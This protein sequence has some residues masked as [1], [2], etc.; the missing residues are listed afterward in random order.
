MHDFD[1]HKK[2]VSLS[3]NI[4]TNQVSDLLTHNSFLL[5]KES[6]EKENSSEFLI[7]EF[8]LNGFFKS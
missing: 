3:R 4:A 5:V 2:I 1:D 7:N 6:L 8:K